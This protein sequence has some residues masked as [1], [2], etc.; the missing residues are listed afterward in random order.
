[1]IV[2]SLNDTSVRHEMKL[3]FRDHAL[4]KTMTK[5]GEMERSEGGSITEGIGQGR[6]TGNLATCE[7]MIDS[8]FLVRQAHARR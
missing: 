1:M 4:P 7:G 6:V 3:A 5:K 8:A 2:D